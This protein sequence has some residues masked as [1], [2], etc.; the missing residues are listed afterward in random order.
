[1]KSQIIVIVIVVLIAANLLSLSVKT[2]LA[3]AA[4]ICVDKNNYTSVIPCSDQNAIDKD[5]AKTNQVSSGNMTVA[6]SMPKTSGPSAAVVSAPPSPNTTTTSKS[7]TLHGWTLPYTGF[8]PNGNWTAKVL[9]VRNGE[10]VEDAQYDSDHN[11]YHYVFCYVPGE[12]SDGTPFV[13]PRTGLYEPTTP[14]SSSVP[15]NATTTTLSNSSST[16]LTNATNA[17][18]RSEGGMCPVGPINMTRVPCDQVQKQQEINAGIITINVPSHNGANNPTTTVPTTGTCPGGVLPNMTEHANPVCPPQPTTTEQF[19]PPDQFLAQNPHPSQQQLTHW[20]YV[21][22]ATGHT[23]D[24]CVS[25]S[26]QMGVSHEQV[27]ADLLPQFLAAHGCAP[28]TISHGGTSGHTAAYWD[29]YNQ[30]KTDKRNGNP[31]DAAATCDSFSFGN[32]KDWSHCVAGYDDAISGGGSGNP[33]S[34]PTTKVVKQSRQYDLG[35]SQGISDWNQYSSDLSHSFE[36]PLVHVAPHSDYCK[37]YDA[38]LMFEN[39]DQ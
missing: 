29:G 20:E 23:P 19:V 2:N 13:N 3:N 25:N 18:M 15:T 28:Q 16:P 5:S 12:H 11:H 39:S 27:C 35:Y 10:F 26:A 14:T 21:C 33:Q 9:D 6:G 17:A 8:C 31:I 37:G 22:E 38:A 34:T 36:C 4:V 7:A 30:G 32:N 1:M 24:Y